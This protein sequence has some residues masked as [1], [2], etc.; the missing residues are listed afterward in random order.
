[1]GR[2]VVFLFLLYVY[3][4]R[5]RFLAAASIPFFTPYPAAG[6]TPPKAAALPAAAKAGMAKANRGKILP[7]C[8]CLRPRRFRLGLPWWMTGLIGENIYSF[9]RRLFNL[10]RTRLTAS[11]IIPLTAF[12]SQHDGQTLQGGSGQ[13]SGE[14]KPPRCLLGKLLL[15]R[16]PLRP[17]ETFYF[18]KWRN[19]LHD[20]FTQQFIATIACRDDSSRGRSTHIACSN[21][22]GGAPRFRNRVHKQSRSSLAGWRSNIK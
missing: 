19:S 20:F 1:M 18:L 12:F 8:L 11:L 5:R 6:L 3:R 15:L 16:F 10:R 4:L 13:G 22:T 2:I 9:E 14:M 21:T 17:G 7:R